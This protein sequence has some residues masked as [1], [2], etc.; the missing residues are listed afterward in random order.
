MRLGAIAVLFGMALTLAGCDKCGNPNLT[1]IG[2]PGACS[3]V[4]P[5]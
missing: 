2:K 5:G 1:G 3:D 4:R